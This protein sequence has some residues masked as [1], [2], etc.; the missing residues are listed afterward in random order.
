MTAARL[1]SV[2]IQGFKSF[3]E[4]THVEFGPGISAVVGPNGSGK[5]NLADALRWA[6]G[7]QGRALRSRRSEDVIWAGSQRRPAVGLADV[8]LS[9][10]NSD[11]LL[12]V[13]Y[14]V[15]ELGRRLYRSGENDYLLN[16]QRVRLRD[17]MDLL[18]A[19]H[20]AENAFLFIG[21]GTVD[22]ALALRPE[23]RR[24]LFE[25]VA[26]VRRHDRRRR[27]AIEQLEES[28][29]NLART[30]DIIAELRPQARRLAAQAEQQATRESAADELASAIVAAGHA[31]WHAA[32]GRSSAATASAESARTAVDAALAALTAAEE[33]AAA[34]AGSLTTR[35]ASEAELRAAAEAARTQL[36]ALQVRDER[37]QSEIAALGRERGRLVS[38]RE[39]AETDLVAQ[40]R[41]LAGALPERDPGLDEELAEVSR[42]LNEVLVRLGEGGRAAASS[43]QD[44]AGRVAAARAAELEGLRRRVAEAERTAGHD[45]E[46][47]AAAGRERDDRAKALEQAGAATAAALAGETRARQGR[48]AAEAALTDAAAAARGAAERTARAAASLAG[49]VARVETVERAI[50]EIEGG[51]FAVAAKARGGRRLGRDLVLDP[52]FRPAIDA[53]LAGLGRAFVVDRDHVL[54]LRNERGTAVVRDQAGADRGARRDDRAVTAMLEVVAARGG[55]R[56]LDAIRRDDDGAVRRL[57]E[58]VVWLPDLPSCL[59]VQPDLPPGWVAV[60]RDGSAVA[61]DLTVVL[62]PAG[63]RLLERQAE[64]ERLAGELEAARAAHAEAA[65]AEASASEVERQARASLV[66]ARALEASAAA[67]R[68][69]AEDL[70]RAALRAA[71]AATREA[72]WLST[73]AERSASD[74]ARLRSGL[75]PEASEAHDDATRDATKSSTGDKASDV[76]A[77]ESRATELRARR[78]RLA[79]AVAESDAARRDAE[80]RHAQAEATAALDEARIA[81]ADREVAAIDEQ[82]AALTGERAALLETLADAGVTEAARREELDQ[83]TAADAAD[84]A[85]LATAEQ[86]A[87]R[88]RDDLRRTEERARTAEREEL[89]SRLGLEALREQL[90]VELAG[91]GSVALR[92]IGVDADDGAVAEDR[93]GADGDPD[94]DAASELESVLAA[95]AERW[96]ATPPPSETPSPGRLASLRRRFHDLGASNPFAVDEYDALRRRLD[97]LESQ[98]ADLR[99]AIDRTRA[100]VEELDVLIAGQFRATFQA[101]EAAFAARFEQLFGG[102][103]ARLSLTDPSDLAATGVEIVASPP[104]KKPQALAMLSGGERALTAVALLFAMLEVRPVPFCVLDEVDAALD[105]ANIGRFTEALAELARSTQCVVITHNRG[106]I[107]VADA[108]YGVTVGDDSVSRVISLRLDEATAI[109]ASAIEG[110]GETGQEPALATAATGTQ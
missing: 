109:A 46:R 72:A 79:A 18:D 90:L 108:I 74:L 56:L 11:G 16:R 110:D 59:A 75:P 7:E 82:A 24:P 98:D 64:Q 99:A 44:D 35:A 93:T 69:R 21:Q 91:L 58:R 89:E 12:P 65:A 95:A 45:S 85:S 27:R 14:A 30:E 78:D 5:S 34:V 33:T 63:D 48:E 97:G 15:V 40:R 31:R 23:E 53:V 88:A 51:S 103:F 52:G 41:R 25:E 60:V 55:G 68:R 47:A 87:A 37:L 4:R 73:R 8:Q 2:R 22:Q 1:L 92:H 101:L 107:E 9:L 50:A 39:A 43:R 10:D 29:S 70:E 102:G 71:D 77:W 86:A 105:E 76:A 84:R 38:D 66:G 61:A 17:L 62:Q 3:A 104:G 20:L 67:D 13:D 81:S 96:A 26:G 106:T 54:E 49:L 57:V 6:L 100:L 42:S 28:E 94:L 19:A 36:T 32:A 83:L 80:R